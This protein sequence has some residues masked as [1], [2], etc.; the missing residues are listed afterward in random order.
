MNASA[1]GCQ[2]I[3]GLLSFG[4]VPEISSRIARALGVW[5]VGGKDQLMNPQW[6]EKAL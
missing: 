6:A 1:S 3:P 2:L 5:E 4:D